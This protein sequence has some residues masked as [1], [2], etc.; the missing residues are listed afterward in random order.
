MHLALMEV[1]LVRRIKC[2]IE[3]VCGKAERERMRENGRER[4]RI[5]SDFLRVAWMR[6][7]CCRLMMKWMAFLLLMTGLAG[8][9]FVEML[10]L[11]R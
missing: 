11:K 1:S 4:E 6:R 2:E 10:L 5:N 3:I 9:I 8:R 7:L